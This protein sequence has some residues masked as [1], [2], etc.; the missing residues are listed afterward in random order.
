MSRRGSGDRRWKRL[1]SQEGMNDLAMLLD[2]KGAHYSSPAGGVQ[3]FEEEMEEM[4]PAGTLRKR[5]HYSSPAGGV[6]YFE[7]EMEVMYPSP[8]RPKLEADSDGNGSDTSGP[9]VDEKDGCVSLIE[10]L[11]WASRIVDE[12]IPEERNRLARWFQTGCL[13]KSNYSGI[14]CAEMAFAN[15]QKALNMKLGDEVWV[16]PIRLVECADTDKQCRQV[17]QARGPPGTTPERCFG[18]ITAR[19]PMTIRQELAAISW[20]SKEDLLQNSRSKMDKLVKRKINKVLDLFEKDGVVA[21]NIDST[22]YD[23]VSGKNVRVEAVD[24]AFVNGERNLNDA[25]CKGM[26]L[27]V[28]GMSCIHFSKAGDMLG[29]AGEG[30]AKPCLVWLEERRHRLE[31]FFTIECVFAHA[32]LVLIHERLGHLYDIQEVTFDVYDLGEPIHRKRMYVSGL[33]RCAVKR[34]EP[35]WDL[36]KRFRRRTVA[37][38]DMYFAL[39]DEHVQPY[40]NAIAKKKCKVSIGEQELTYPEVLAEFERAHAATYLEMRQAMIAEGKLTAS[41]TFVCD[42]MHSPIKS[43]KIG[44]HAMPT[45]T[46]KQTRFSVQRNRCLIGDEY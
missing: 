28:A 6:Q 22:C 31:P 34:L 17:L 44:I 42:L 7:E 11:Q 43:K 12:L 38:P 18:D 46:C 39:S 35:M 16:P 32:L 45:L 19:L 10:S 13:V 1:I 26:R 15:L 14:G 3:Y 8:K 2:T 36:T 24:Q 29:L 40:I 25:P 5:A 33:L 23:Y 30:T 4:C 9:N 21:F 37:S 41:D 20:P 27:V